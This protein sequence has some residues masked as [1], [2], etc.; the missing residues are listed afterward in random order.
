MDD[1]ERLEFDK[2]DANVLYSQAYSFYN[3]GLYNKAKECFRV[4]TAI[5]P[6]NYDY[7]YGLGATY[8]MLKD[9][10]TAIQAYSLGA[11]ADREE[12]DP[13]PHLHA[14]ECLMALRKYDRAE[15]ALQSAEF[16]VRK[17][18]LSSKLIDQI[19]QLRLAMKQ[20]EVP[21]S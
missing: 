6:M 19:A 8:Q 4:L 7:W 1:D 10:A 13:A 14:A 2:T 9:Y 20:E 18:N 17:H 12:K 11:L 15:K 16:I 5:Q 21:Q 3:A